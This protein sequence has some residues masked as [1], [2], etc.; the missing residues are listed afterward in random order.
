MATA[1]ICPDCETN[2]YNTSTG[3]LHYNTG[4]EQCYDDENDPT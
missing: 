1:I 4:T 2:L 3:W